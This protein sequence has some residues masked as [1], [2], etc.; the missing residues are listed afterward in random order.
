MS[1]LLTYSGKAVQEFHI[2]HTKARRYTQHVVRWGKHWGFIQ[3]S[4]NWDTA[5]QAEQRTP[6]ADYEHGTDKFLL[7]KVTQSPLQAPPLAI[8]DMWSEEVIFDRHIKAGNLLYIRGTMSDIQAT[9]KQLNI[10]T[11]P[12]LQQ[13]HPCLLYTSPS[14]RD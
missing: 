7:E 12:W 1:Y 14:P 3:P 9:L 13:A 8:D 5:W 11:P 6:V 4:P 2:S 10:F